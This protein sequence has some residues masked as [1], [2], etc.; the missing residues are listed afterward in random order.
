[1]LAGDLDRGVGSATDEDRNAGAV[2]RLQLREAV[3]DLIIFAAIAERLVRAPFGTDDIEE[4]GSAGIALVLVVKDIAVLSQLGRIAAGD[5]VQGNPSAR[6]LVDS[7]QLSRQQGRRGEAGP[8]RDQDIEP[9]G[10]AK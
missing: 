10:D 8:L 7:G 3:L 6:E 1:M 5:D 9:V 4:L 2:V